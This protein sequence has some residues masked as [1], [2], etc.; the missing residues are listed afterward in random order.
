MSEPKHGDLALCRKCGGIIVF[1]EH[2]VGNGIGELEVLDA[3][4]AHRTHP[5][6]GHE[7][8]P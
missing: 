7:A 1:Y 5:A 6:D 2:S 3:W 8:T 4:W